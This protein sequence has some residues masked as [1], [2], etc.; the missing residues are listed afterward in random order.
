MKDIVVW[1]AEAHKICFMQPV[2][3]P[4]CI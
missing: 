4:H 3:H 2:A 1:Y